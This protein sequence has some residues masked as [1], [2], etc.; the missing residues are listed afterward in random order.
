MTEEKAIYLLICHK[1]IFVFGKLTSQIVKDGLDFEH[2]NNT[3][4]CIKVYIVLVF[5]F[6]MKTVG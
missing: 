6:S 3:L 1:L 2:A 4:T 5:S